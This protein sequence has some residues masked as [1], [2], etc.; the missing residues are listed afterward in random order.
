MCYSLAGY[1]TATIA[2]LGYNLDSGNS[3]GLAAAGDMTNTDPLLGLLTNNGGPLAADGLPPFTQALAK[4]SPAIDAIPN[5]ACAVALD[6]RG[7]LRPA[8]IGC[9]IGAYEIQYVTYLPLINRNY[10]LPDGF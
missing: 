4:S 2:S 3:C 9:D 1:G 10:S 8:G 7:A 5:A 6:E